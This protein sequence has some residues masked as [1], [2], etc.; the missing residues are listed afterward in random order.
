[1]FENFGFTANLIVVEHISH[2]LLALLVKPP[3]N[4]VSCG[5]DFIEFNHSMAMN[6][7]E[8]VD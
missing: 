8:D 1:M 5:P 6:A 4:L 2:V 3:A 7:D